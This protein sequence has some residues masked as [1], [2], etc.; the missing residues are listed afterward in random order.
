MKKTDSCMFLVLKN[1]MGWKESIYKETLK[2]MQSIEN[3]IVEMHKELLMDMN[4]V[5]PI[6]IP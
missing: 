2:E 1:N 6:G 5:N 4:I 3:K